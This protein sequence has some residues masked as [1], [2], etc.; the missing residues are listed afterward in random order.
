MD[1]H[2]LE[3]QAYQP[4]IDGFNFSGLT[5]PHLLFIIGICL[6]NLIVPFLNIQLHKILLTWIFIFPIILFQV[7]PLTLYGIKKS[8][9]Y[10]DF[11]ILCVFFFIL[12]EWRFMQYYWS[13]E[14][15]NTLKEA[16]K[17]AILGLFILS[18]YINFM[19]M[20]VSILNRITSV[21]ITIIL[22]A[23]ILV[24]IW[25]LL[26]LYGDISLYGNH[27]LK[28][29][30]TFYG[31]SN[32]AGAAILL[33]GSW[34]WLLLFSKKSGYQKLGLYNLIITLF[35]LIGISSYASLGGYLISIIVLLLL[36]LWQKK[37]KPFILLIMGVLGIIA[38]GFFL[39]EFIFTPHVEDI[40][41]RTFYQRVAIWLEAWHT[42]KEG[43]LLYGIGAA[44][45][46]GSGGPGGVHNALLQSWLEG[47]IIE[48]ILHLWLYV[49]LI[50]IGLKSKSKEGIVLVALLV[51]MFI[52]NLAESNGFLFGSIDNFIVFLSWYVLMLVF[53]LNKKM[54]RHR[55]LQLS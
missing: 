35:L 37:Y 36:I 33:M 8:Y 22:S 10:N 31:S 3:K 20:N 44:A 42:L 41:L 2:F 43:A 52:R 40:F 7:F 39:S 47:G 6:I 46:S 12:I 18:M 16:F 34:N 54:D 25:Q 55:L 48:L 29:N 26:Y 51:S 50:R 1:R 23:T 21:S 15:N 45:W 38:A 30:I 27:H 49:W 13:V 53:I 28:E 4:T 17:T 11:L 14:P 9:N 32:S 5:V 19:Q 24:Y